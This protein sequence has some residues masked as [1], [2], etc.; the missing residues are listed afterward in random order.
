MSRNNL[1]I[2]LVTLLLVGGCADKSNIQ[3]LD[4]TNQNS[5]KFEKEL[6]YIMHALYYREHGDYIKAYALFDKLYKETQK[7]EYKI[8]SLK[9]LISLGGY[10]S[11][12][13]EI[14]SFLKH[15]PN[16]VTLY[17]LLT[18]VELKQN[19]I[20]KALESAKKALKIE[21]ESMENI[22]L[23]ASIYIIMKEYQKAIDLYNKYYTKH[24]DE[25]S[26]IKIASITY[27]KLKDVKKTVQILRSHTQFIGCSEKACTF[28]AEIYRQNSDL[29]NMAKI[30]ANL[31]KHTKKS[32]YA[33]KAAEIYAY[34]KKYEKAI[35]LLESSKTDNRLL[36]AILKQTHKFKKAAKLAKKLYDESLDSVWLAEY[37]I[38]LF[39]SAKNKKDKKL[40]ERVVDKLSRAIKE[41]L[42]EPI[43]YNYL[44]YLL[45][46]NDI[47]IKR[48]IK[49]VKKA[50]KSE[51][52][53]AFYID[54]LAWG[55][56]KLGR[57]EE[58]YKLMKKVIKKLGSDDEEIK[59]H[60][61]KIKKCRRQNAL[62][63]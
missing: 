16:N 10:D 23:V 33:Q 15:Y 1:F 63:K 8:E 58:A 38:M 45:I 53:S 18:L 60:L 5:A 28:L 2:I 32:E 40:L 30:Y 47:D 39:E 48:G 34:E 51:P 61:K 49:L 13:K 21:P 57:C 27:H 7:L 9:L 19:Y 52:D 11:A 46:D 20:N 36:L 25:Q 4:V 26:L 59:N 37:G 29:N 62:S 44:G 22:D 54:S 55:Y 35:E 31:Y 6:F 43:Y 56:Y 3:N 50:L 17:R 42:D 12:Q 24:H 41:G 14:I